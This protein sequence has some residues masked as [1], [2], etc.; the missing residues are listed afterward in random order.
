MKTAIL[1]TVY[2]EEKNIDYLLSEIPSSYDVYIV[3][4]GSTDNTVKVAENAGAQV[5]KLPLNVGQ[6]A[7]TIAGYKLLINKQYEVL[8]KMDGDGQH[9]PDQIPVFLEKL[10]YS[11][12][13]IVVGSRILGTNYKNA[14]F[15]RRTFLPVYTLLINKLTGYKLTDS[16][17]GFRAFKVSALRE[18]IDILDNLIEPQYIASEMFIRF[19]KAGLSIDE[20]PISMRERKSGTSYKGFIR[21]GMG[22]LRAIIRT[23]LDKNFRNIKKQ[24]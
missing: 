24:E 10:E 5:I 19:S 2:N 17:S 15:F 6:G 16:M 20:V 21:Y 18:V 1:I 22:V 3:D 23:L 12:V 9:N 11:G 8:I 14:P 4:D 13:D 7:A